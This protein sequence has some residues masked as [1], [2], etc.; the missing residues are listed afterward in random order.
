MPQ[1]FT[2][3]FE[4]VQDISQKF[5]NELLIVD[6]SYQRRKVWNPQDKVRLI[7]TILL[8]LVMP[9]VFFWSS[10]TDPMTGNTIT[11]IV[12]GQQRITTIIE[13]VNNEFSLNERF[14]L[15]DDMK[16]NYAG[17]YFEDLD[18]ET[19]INFWNYQIFII[20]IDRSLQKDDIKNLFYRVNLTNYSLNSQEKLNSTDSK[21]GDLA[22][23]LSELDFWKDCRVFSATDAKRMQDVRYCC[24][25]YILANEGIVDQAGDKKINEYYKDYAEEFDEENILREKIEKAMEIISSLRD[26]STQNFIS[27]KAQL[28]TLFCFA[29]KMVDNKV[30]FSTDIFQKFKLF[31]QAYNKFR[32][33]YEINFPNASLRELNESIKKYKLASSEGINK[34]N[35]RM[36]RFKTLYQVCVDSDE[37]IKEHLKSI[38]QMYS[39]Q[40]D[41]QLV[42]FEDLDAE[43]LLDIT[44]I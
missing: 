27:K 17:K 24:S 11:H 14:F 37:S 18:T 19:K 30:E 35:N 44:N 22:I 29:F 20:N 3:N 42:L 31:V 9:E 7:E 15:D 39:S 41:A 43:D 8:G 4:T 38:Q 10:E 28:Y 25:I 33:E 26:K 13:F 16:N 1:L 23:K 32:N 34:V 40:G 2:R 21:F 6:P 5:S 12:D 36:I